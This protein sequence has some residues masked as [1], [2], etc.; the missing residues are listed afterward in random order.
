MYQKPS[1]KYSYIPPLSSHQPSIFRSFVREELRRYLLAC[2]KHED[3]ISLTKLFQ[4]R[5][6]RR[7]YP[8]NTVA[9]ALSLLPARAE[10]VTRLI[11]PL[12]RTSESRYDLLHRKAPIIV[13]NLPNLVP[14]PKWNDVFRVPPVLSQLLEYKIAY[15]SSSSR[16][17]IGHRNHK[18]VWHIVTSSYYSNSTL[19][20]SNKRIT[21]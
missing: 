11:G 6:Q 16:I 10:I 14:S 13:L 7:G 9:L 17:I 2:S 8:P 15:F 5:L 12:T 3:V 20:A 1:N 19:D 18:N 4:E 21:F